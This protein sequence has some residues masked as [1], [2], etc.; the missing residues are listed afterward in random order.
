MNTQP[1]PDKPDDG[2]TP[3]SIRRKL[4]EVDRKLERVDER[5]DWLEYAVD[6]QSRGEG[7]PGET[8]Q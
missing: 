4:E 1:L 5:L 2:E 6:V 8:L 7:L 3:A